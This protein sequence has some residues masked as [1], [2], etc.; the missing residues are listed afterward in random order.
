[1]PAVQEEIKEMLD[2]GVIVP[3]KS[4]YSSPIVMV[5]KKDGTNRMCIDYRKLNEITT[6]D[7]YP[8]PRIGQTIDA[9][10]GAGY[11]SSLDLASGYWQVP[12]AEKDRHKTAFCTPEGGLYEFVKMPLGLTNAPA[13]FQ[14]LMN[15][16]FKEDIFKHVLIFLDDLLVYSETPEEHL[17]H[18][19][20][21]FLKLRAAGLKSKPKKCDLFKT[22]VNYLGHVL[23]KTGIR[24]DPKKLEAVRDWE[25]P[26]TVTQVKSF[27]AFCNYYRKFVK[28]FAEVAKPLYRLTSKGVKFAWEKEHEDAFQLL[29]TRLLQA[30]ILALPNFRHP[31]VIDTDAS[32]TALGA[33][34]SQIIDGEE[35]PIAFESRVLSKTEVNYATTKREALGIVQAMQW[36]RPYIYGSQCIVRTDHASLQWLFRQNADGMTFRMIQKMQE[37]NYRI[38]HRPGEKH[39]NADG[40][41]RRPNERPEWKEGEEEELRGQIPEFQTMEKALGGAQDDLNSGSSLKKKSD[42]VIAHARMH[43]PHPPREVV[44]YATGNFMESSYSLVFCVSGD[45]RVKSSPMTEFVDRYSHLRPTEDSVNRVGGML[46]YWDSVQPRY[47]YLLM[48]KEKYTDV[49]KYDDL[50]SCLRE[51]SAHAALKGVSCFAMPRIGVVDDRLE[52][53]NV[54]ICL[55]SIFQD[56]YCTLTV[57]T[58]EAEQ[59]FYPIP[60]HSRGNT[61]REGNLCAVATPEEMLMNK[62][63]KERISWT[64]SDSELAKRQRADSALKIIIC[65]LERYGVNLEDSHCTFGKNPISK[66]EAQS[67]GNLEAL[68]F[69]SNW[70]DFA[71]SNGV[72]YRKWKPSNRVNECWQA[73]IPKDMRNEI[74]YQLHDSPM[75]GGHFGVEK[76]LARIKQRFWWPSL[77]T[78]VEKHIA[79]CDR[80][81][82]R[83]TAGI[84]RKAELQTFSV[85]GALRTMAADILGPVTL[86]RKSKARYI[87]VMSDLFTKYA[88]AVAL[89]DMTAAT[90]A[91]A[92]ID[93]WIIKFGAPDVIHTDQGSNFNSELMHDNCRIFMIE[94]TRTTPYHPQ[95]NGQV[96][97]FNRVIA[98][99]LSKYCAEKPQEWDVYL[100]YITFVYNTTVHRTIGATPY[101]MIFG[102][103]AQYPIDLFV[104]K[105]PGDPRLKL[106]EHA[107]ELNERLYEIHREAQMT[108]GTEQRRQREYFNRKVHVEPFKEGDLVWLF[109][110]HKAKSRKFYLPWHGPFDVLSRTSEVTYMICKRGN[111]EKWQKVHFNRLKPYRGNPEIRHSGRLKNRP[112]PIYEEI[113]HDVETEEENEDSPFHVIE[114]TTAESQAAGNRPKVT[115]KTIPEIVE[116]DS[117]SET[118]ITPHDENVERQTSPGLTA[119]ETIPGDDSENSESERSTVRNDA[120][121]RPLDTDNDS[122]NESQRDSDVPTGRQS[123]VR[124]PPVRFGIDEFVNRCK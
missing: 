29:K 107:E 104:P 92:I 33:V 8:L 22:Q 60:S 106:G 122:Q 2:K 55:E 42:D 63:V 6:K 86:A 5:P 1:M 25:R 53:T 21:V 95:G 72:L 38:V 14:R 59:D 93:E 96:E 26:K 120:P 74:L 81:A 39:C 119:Y 84:K 54:A 18:L 101:S 32:E 85:H 67:W 45:M 27:T 68:E 10:Q 36:F 34:L 4:P 79:N 83:S 16:I 58:L 73:I 117:D 71:T 24:P 57:Y 98:D 115:F 89:Q 30:P 13:T 28:N 109:E 20:K 114:T 97:R 77:K 108:M 46:V 123:R 11:F 7:A 66:E 43:I 90:V 49:A 121:E 113:P 110:P 23:D 37:Y 62:G 111:K 94:K 118:E 88:V 70:E 112:P 3:S 80:C 40:L 76:T 19:E 50:N 47:I 91:N 56:V 116:Q 35:R 48:T 105:P 78:S 15:K 102:R 69:W 100:P 61:S 51:M 124:R 65:A 82:A 9:L 31:F 99:T 87:L 75:S 52:W 17:E 44:K 41:S 12:V 64:R 103:E